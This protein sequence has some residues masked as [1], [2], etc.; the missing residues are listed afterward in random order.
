MGRVTP[1]EAFKHVRL[2]I[3][4]ENKPLKVTD[5]NFG[6][7]IKA[8]LVIDW[9]DSNPAACLEDRL[10]FSVSYRKEIPFYDLRVS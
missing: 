10:S 1:F 5:G 4:K 7:N 8:K 2:V 6:D 9:N 3:G